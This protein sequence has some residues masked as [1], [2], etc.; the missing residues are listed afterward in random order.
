MVF[1][2]IAA[3]C[4]TSTPERFVVVSNTQINRN[5]QCVVAGFDP[6]SVILGSPFGSLLPCATNALILPWVLTRF[7]IVISQCVD[8]AWQYKK[9]ALKPLPR[10]VID[11]HSTLRIVCLNSRPAH[12]GQTDGSSMIRSLITVGVISVVTP[13]HLI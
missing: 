1:L 3:F 4:G 8:N 13:I 5:N 12:S 7:T 10:N 9:F 6:V 11:N 2:I